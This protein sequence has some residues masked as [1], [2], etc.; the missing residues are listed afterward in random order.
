MEDTPSKYAIVIEYVF[1]CWLECCFSVWILFFFFL[2]TDVVNIIRQPSGAT[3]REARTPPFVHGYTTRGGGFS[4]ILKVGVNFNW[5]N[6]SGQ[7][8]AT[9]VSG[10][11]HPVTTVY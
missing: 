5:G 6:R 7:L 4:R 10:G 3:P 2:C 8:N 11:V 1:R 9:L